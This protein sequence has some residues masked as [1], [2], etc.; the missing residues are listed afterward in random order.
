MKKTLTISLIALFFT[1]YIA[2][3]SVPNLLNYGYRNGMESTKAASHII[4]FV[5]LGKEKITLKNKTT[6]SFVI[7]QEEFQKLT[8]MKEVFSHFANKYLIIL[9]NSGALNLTKSGV[10]FTLSDRNDNSVTFQMGTKEQLQD[11]AFRILRAKVCD[12][13]IAICQ[14]DNR[15]KA[16]EYE[17]ELKDKDLS[18][19]RI[20]EIIESTSL[21]SDYENRKIVY[22]AYLQRNEIDPTM[23]SYVVTQMVGSSS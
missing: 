8:T 3:A 18:K 7:S 23:T 21:F 11:E 4:R 13:L 12:D 5:S 16:K 20:K 22:S 6:Y 17:K 1:T 14:L 9:L 19:E 2:Q 15:V 10:N